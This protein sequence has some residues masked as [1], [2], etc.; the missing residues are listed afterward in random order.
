MIYLLLN[1]SLFKNEIIRSLSWCLVGHTC[2]TIFQAVRSDI[3]NIIK[4][5]QL[6]EKQAALSEIK[7][8]SAS[9]KRQSFCLADISKITH[10]LT[11]VLFV[12]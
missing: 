3:I 11:V 6:R 1:D 2:L 8:N 9:K 10:R 7:A 12:N 5:K 4:L